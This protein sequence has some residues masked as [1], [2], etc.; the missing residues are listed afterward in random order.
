MTY[1]ERLNIMKEL[2]RSLTGIDP[3][4][5]QTLLNRLYQNAA[6]KGYLNY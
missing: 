2:R 3:E 4:V 6:Y 5:K 1:K